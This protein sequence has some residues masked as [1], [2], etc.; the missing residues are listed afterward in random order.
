MSKKSYINNNDDRRRKNNV[1][2]WIDH[3]TQVISETPQGTRTCKPV[4]KCIHLQEVAGCSIHIMK[5]WFKR[6]RGHISQGRSER[7]YEGKVV[8][9]HD[10]AYTAIWQSRKRGVSHLSIFKEVRLYR[11]PRQESSSLEGKKILAIGCGSLQQSQAWLGQAIL[12]WRIRSNHSV[13]IMTNR[14][15]DGTR[16]PLNH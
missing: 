14:A 12:I 2:R 11:S 8:S 1:G 13:D 16:I 3:R 6:G 10:I 7:R 5:P 4:T 15:P 9:L